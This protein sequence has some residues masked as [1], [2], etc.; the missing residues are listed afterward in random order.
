MKNMT[1]SAIAE[2]AGGIYKGPAECLSEEVTAV[3][4]DSRKAEKGCL[5]AGHLPKDRTVKTADPAARPRKDLTVKT[6]VPAGC[7]AAV[8]RI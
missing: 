6:E 4:T 2:A 1:L 7:P 8:L 3:V 5:R